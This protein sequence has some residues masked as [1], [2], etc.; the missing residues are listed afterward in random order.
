[1]L[2][3]S[4]PTAL[5]VTAP[6]AC[7]GISPEDFTKLKTATTPIFL[8]AIATDDMGKK[9]YKDAIDNYKEELKSYPDLSA[10]AERRRHQRDLYARSGLRA[11]RTPRTFPTPFSIWHAP[12]NM[13]RRQPKTASRQAAEYWYKKYHG[14]M[15]GF[16]AIKQLAHDNATPP[17]SYKPT[18]APPPPDA[19]DLGPPGPLSAVGSADRH[20]DHGPWRQG[21]RPRQRQR[22]R[23][24]C[25]LGDNEG[26][27][28]TRFP[29]SSFRRP[30]PP[31]SWLSLPTTSSR[32]QKWPTSPST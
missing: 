15:D 7:S 10:Q 28:H 21:V 31:Y 18:A 27:R 19:C 29:E 2:R 23:C 5:K 32:H 22:C 8:S 3:R 16:D 26:C 4:P 25:R 14:G 20:Q 9:D 11:G 13:L 30:R 6:A 24:R 1:M 17:D 12:R